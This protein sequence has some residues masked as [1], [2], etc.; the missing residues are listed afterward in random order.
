MGSL[1]PKEVKADRKNIPDSRLLSLNKFLFFD[2]CHGSLITK[3]LTCQ[4]SLG[5]FSGMYFLP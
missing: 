2:K 4:T 3:S 1:T 5:V